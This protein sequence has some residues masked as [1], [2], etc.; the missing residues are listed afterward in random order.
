VTLAVRKGVPG[1]EETCCW[2]SRTKSSQFT[3]FQ[4]TYFQTSTSLKEN[5][6]GR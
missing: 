6:A 1:V 2:K 4:V 3:Q 5:T